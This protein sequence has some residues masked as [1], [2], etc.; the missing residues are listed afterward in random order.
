MAWSGL[1]FSAVAGNILTLYPTPKPNI[2]PYRKKKAWVDCIACGVPRLV[3]VDPKGK[4][5]GSGLCKGCAQRKRYEHKA[6]R[7]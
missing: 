4:P 6:V 2:E 3:T 1:A 7:V 5:Y